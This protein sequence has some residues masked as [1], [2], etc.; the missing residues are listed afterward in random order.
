MLLLTVLM[1]RQQIRASVLI[2]CFLLAWQT[3][4]ISFFFPK[5]VVNLYT[6]IASFLEVCGEIFHFR[7]A[8][9]FRTQRQWNCC[10]SP[11][12]GLDAFPLWSSQTGFSRG[13]PWRY[14]PHFPEKEVETQG[15]QMFDVIA[16]GPNEVRLCAGTSVCQLWRDSWV[17]L[18]KQ[19]VKMNYSL[20]FSKNKQITN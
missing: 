5:C 7:K 16:T 17:F 18:F 10:C 13:G 19:P 2:S 14:L 9:W 20:F 1:D 3:C 6:W 12:P 4:A 15:G 11:F 8:S